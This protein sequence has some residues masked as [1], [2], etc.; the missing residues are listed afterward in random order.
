METSAKKMM[1]ADW[2]RY[3]TLLMLK[4]ERNGSYALKME[5]TAAK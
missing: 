3:V 1:I 2:V 5:G 4:K